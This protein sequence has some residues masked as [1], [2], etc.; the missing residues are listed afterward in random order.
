MK[1]NAMKRCKL[2]SELEKPNRDECQLVS[3]FVFQ[4]NKPAIFREFKH[5]VRCEWTPNSGQGQ[6]DLVFSNDEMNRFLVV[7]AKAIHKHDKKARQKR[8]KT[9]RQSRYY[10]ACLEDELDEDQIV[11]AG[12]LTEPR[13][14][15]QFLDEAERD[16]YLEVN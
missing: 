4:R 7:E 6:G 11:F 3:D 16:E 12:I 5:L 8:K 1:A 14:G 15:F 13:G 9:R 10:K 2:F